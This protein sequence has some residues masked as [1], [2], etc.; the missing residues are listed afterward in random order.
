MTKYLFNLRVAP[1][2]IEQDR[3]TRAMPDSRVLQLRNIKEL[4]S[5][6]TIDLLKE[7]QSDGFEISKSSLNAYLN[8]YTKNQF[9]QAEL[10]RALQKIETRLRRKYSRYI[11]KP[12]RELLDEWAH[13]LQ[14][15]DA[16]KN[17]A[18]ASILGHDQSTIFKWH[19][20]DIKPKPLWLV[21]EMQKRVDR[22]KGKK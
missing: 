14:I 1:V 5:L 18:L 7:L 21:I 8:G 9:K 4:L 19:K 13:E 22:A 15:G 12:M 20:Y 17:Q 11:D 10:L 3:T 2:T 16:A 6:R